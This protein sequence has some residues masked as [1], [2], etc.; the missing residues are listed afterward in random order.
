MAPGQ[1]PNGSLKGHRF[2]ATG[3]VYGKPKRKTRSHLR[4]RVENRVK[5]GAY[6]SLAPLATAL[7]AS[8]TT[9]ACI[10]RSP[11]SFWKL[12]TSVF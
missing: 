7:P 5:R 12:A 9:T 10:P 1:K 3:D 6:G 2:L 8:G 11:V 4:L